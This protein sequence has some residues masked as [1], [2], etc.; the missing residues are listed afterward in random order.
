MGHGCPGVLEGGT[1]TSGR[2]DHQAGWN[3]DYSP[4]P[5]WAKFRAEAYVLAFGLPSLC[6]AFPSLTLVGQLFLSPQPC[7]G[8]EKKAGSCF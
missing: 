5:P 6:G 7:S 2:Y 8:A 3:A 1:H 4:C